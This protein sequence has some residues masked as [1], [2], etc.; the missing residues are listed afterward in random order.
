MADQTERTRA[1][2][3]KS[4]LEMMYLDPSDSR[5]ALIYELAKA[6]I[7]LERRLDNVDNK[8]QMQRDTE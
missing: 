4:R 3:V 8:N 5:Q 2:V 7:E 6:L 1:E